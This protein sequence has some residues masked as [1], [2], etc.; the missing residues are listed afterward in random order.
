MLNKNIHMCTNMCI[1]M[2]IHTHI[3]TY[4]Y[5]YIFVYMYTYMHIHI[6]IYIYINTLTHTQFLAPV[7]LD[8]TFVFALHNGDVVEA[9]V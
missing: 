8:W 3:D 5:I 9:V 7:K 2:S 4:T 1:Y 6:Y